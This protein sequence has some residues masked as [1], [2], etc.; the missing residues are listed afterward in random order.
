MRYV[1][2]IYGVLVPALLLW[3][4]IA[5]ALSALLRR[6]MQRFDLYRLVW[7]RALFDFA[8]FVCLLGVVVYLSEYLA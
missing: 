6:F 7:H 2:D 8:I 5:F 4:I 1:I 3:I